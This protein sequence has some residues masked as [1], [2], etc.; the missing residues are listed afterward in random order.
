MTSEGAA[1]NQPMSDGLTV[2]SIS[3]GINWIDRTL[4]PNQ[5][6][7]AAGLLVANLIVIVMSVE[8]AD[9]VPSPNLV[10]LLIIS[11]LTGLFL[12][13]VRLWSIALVPIG[14]GVGLVVIFWQ[15][16]IYSIDNVEVS[17]VGEVLTRFNL[18]LT[19]ARDGSI[20]I[21]KLPFIFV[22]MVS[23]WITGFLAVS[24]THLTLPTKA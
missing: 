11:M 7:V 8:R 12:Y 23:T 24:Y 2:K 17:G 18:W 5:G 22:L 3:D 15:L 19:S 21:D 16:S 10:W 9:W 20:N 6:W 13:R 14:L 1:A 4:R